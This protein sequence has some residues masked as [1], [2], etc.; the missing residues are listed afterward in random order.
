ME[1]KIDNRKKIA[2]ITLRGPLSREEIL[3]AFDEV[4]ADK[5]YKKGMGR[6]WDFREADLS[7]LTTDT[8]KQMAQYSLNFP[9]G[10]NDVK[11]AF[12]TSRPLEYGLSR[13]FE[14]TSRAKT[15]LRVFDNIDEAQKW[16]MQADDKN[17][18]Q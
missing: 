14:M 1:L 15:P 16:M 6:L 10:I 12:V 9:A 5:N 2:H 17:Q 18:A 4:V 11:V 3:K 8:V 13:M 7:L